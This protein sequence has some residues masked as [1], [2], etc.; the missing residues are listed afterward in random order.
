VKRVIIENVPEF[1]SWGPL[2]ADGKPVKSRKGETF[3]AFIGALRSL[4]YETDWRVLTAA[5]YG[6]PT[7]R[8]RLF[9][10]AVK[11]RKRILWPEIT[12][13]EETD[14]LMGYKPWR[15]ARE[16]I[17]WSLPGTSIF[18]R[19]RPL[20]EATIRRIAVGIEKYWKEEAKPFLAVLY[21]T[22][23]VRSLERPF[24]TV[25]TCGSHHALIQP[26]I[27]NIGQASAKNRSRS[28]HEPLTTIVVKA[29]HCLI[30]PFIL[31]N[32]IRFRMLKN[33]ELKK[34]QGFPENY[35]ITGNITEQTK[36]IGNA[37]PVN[38]AKALVRAIMTG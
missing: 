1:L 22:N 15:T 28:I 24:P 6:D 30:E 29:E 35:V 7:T 23:D 25:T 11:G 33:H 14:N 5:D 16:I 34:A 13:M 2:A 8:R 3:R 17:D 20:A 31:P 26:F 38:T 27:T 12:H 36:Q 19:K 18:D 4:G 9:I 21:G 10:Q 32:D 37:V